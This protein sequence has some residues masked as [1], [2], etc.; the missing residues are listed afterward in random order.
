MS[1][2]HVRAASRLALAP[3]LGGSTMVFAQVAAE[4]AIPTVVVTAQHL[5]QILVV[6]LPGAYYFVFT[7]GGKVG[8]YQTGDTA[9]V[10][11]VA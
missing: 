8:I 9:P 1:R 3:L 2:A 10:G 11:E 4:T 7:M 6:G 5:I